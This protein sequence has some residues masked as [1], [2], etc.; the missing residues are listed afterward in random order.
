MRR[1]AVIGAFAI[2][3]A[4]NL[5]LLMQNHDLKVG[6]PSAASATA[7]TAQLDGSEFD[8]KGIYTYPGF[9]AWMVP[10]DSLGHPKVAPLTL[11]V[12]LSRGSS[13]P[14]RLSEVAV[15]Q[16]LLPVFQ[17]RGQQIIAVAAPLDTANICEHLSAGALGIPLVT[18]DPE[19]TMSVGLTFEEMGI[20]PDNMPFKVL[21][22][23]S[24]TAIYMRGSDNTPESQKEFEDAMLGLS[25]WVAEGRL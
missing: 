5:F 1:S 21:F 9:G 19:D 24:F 23:S 13:C 22:D 7:T 14:S 15:Y 3:I 10:R 11:V 18:Y 2:L 16:R 17:Q 20:S 4:L 8:L 25:R 12:F 6:I